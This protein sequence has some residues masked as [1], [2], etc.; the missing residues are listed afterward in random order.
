MEVSTISLEHTGRFNRLILDYLNKTSE[1]SEFYG[2]SHELENYPKKIEERKQFPFHRDLLAD[3]LIT[4]YKSIGSAEGSVLKNI[5]SLRESNTFTV[6]TGHQLNI[7]TGPLY[8]IYKIL[9]TIKL[10]DELNAAY[11][12]NRFVPVYWMNS[13]DHDIDEI[14]QFNLFGKKYNWNTDQTGATGRM[15]PASLAEFCNQLDEVFSNDEATQQ[16]VDLFRKSYSK[17]EKLTDAT[18]NFVNE[19]F[20]NRGLVIID[21]DDTRLKATFVDH[22][23]ADIFENS[24]F[25]LVK[26]ASLKLGKLNYHAQVNPR[27][28]N[29]FYLA[30][31]YRNRIVKSETGYHV[32]HTKF[33]FTEEELETEI[34]KHPE[35][36]S[37][38]VVLRPLFQEFILPNL[39]YVGGAGELSYWI[40]YRDY[41]SKMRVSY[42]MLGL[43]NHFLLFDS[44]SSSKMEELNLLPED[45]FHSVD[46]LIKEHVIESSDAEVDV[47]DEQEILN[48]LYAKL[49]EKAD[50][51][52][53]S[54]VQSIAAEQT[55]MQKGL[56]QWQ[57][58]FT[59]GLK[60]QN[61]VSVNRIK[62]L[63]K[64]LFPNGYLQERHDNFMAFYSK[65]P[66]GF[67]DL[68]YDATAPFETEFRAV[69]F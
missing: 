60:K 17:F 27:E 69:T 47:S 30:D 16:L 23:K 56:E 65:D 42:P 12:E 10:A 13:E 20:G 51:I 14:G 31:G 49:K 5:E 48:Q 43:R 54:L 37:P 18:R 29:C 61:E 28:V 9:H 8:F 68:I 59:R 62:A 63:H 36:F 25:G 24:P 52:D 67:F 11:P 26:S 50:S 53:S 2:L 55:K 66:D 22:F 3:S 40:Q 15:N 46:D 57:N 6:T 21:S 19:L 35:N 41:F 44:N 39:T 4:Q 33:R 34:D 64:K 32:L 58:R 38:N 45:L 1:L 7:F